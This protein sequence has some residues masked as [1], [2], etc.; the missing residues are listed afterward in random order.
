MQHAPAGLADDGEGLGQDLVEDVL[1]RLVFFVGIFDG[2]D[3]L[4]DALAE[5][6]GLGAKLLVGKLLHRRL[7]R[8]DLL[9]PRL[10]ALEFAFV[11]GAENCGNNFVKQCCGP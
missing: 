1:Q 7:E 4:A 3:A 11:T 6:V 2:V 5:L 8:I 9:D 10:N